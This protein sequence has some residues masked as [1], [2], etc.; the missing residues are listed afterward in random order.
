VLADVGLRDPERVLVRAASAAP[1]I[2]ALVGVALSLAAR[3]GCR[4]RRRST[5]SASPVTRSGLPHPDRAANYGEDPH[6]L[7]LR[8]VGGTRVWG[9]RVV[10]SEETATLSVKLPPDRYKLWCSLANHRALGMEA[11]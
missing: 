6:D 4:S 10:P 11:R 2:G 7:R 1:T 9:T 8:R 3:R 5:T